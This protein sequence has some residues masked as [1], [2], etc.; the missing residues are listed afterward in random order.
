MIIE[1]ECDKLVFDLGM[2]NARFHVMKSTGIAHGMN[3]PIAF[4]HIFIW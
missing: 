4:L 1:F 3:L 2:Q